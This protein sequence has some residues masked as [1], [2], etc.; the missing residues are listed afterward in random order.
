MMG[1]VV[2]WPALLAGT[3]A[4][5]AAG[6][7]A[8]STAGQAE[9]AAEDC[10]CCEQDWCGCEGCVDCHAYLKAKGNAV[11]LDAPAAYAAAGRTAWWEAL[12]WRAA[13]MPRWRPVKDEYLEARNSTL[14]DAGVGLFATVSLPAGAV[15]PP[16]KGSILTYAESKRGGPS[17]WCP[18]G[19]GAKLLGMDSDTAM[20]GPEANDLS[21][22][23]NGAAAV[24][25]NPSPL[26]NSAATK[27]ECELVNVEICEIG[28]V[29]YYRTTKPV[30][31][32]VELVTE[33][34]SNYWEDLESC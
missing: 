20:S 3:S 18:A 4:A 31:K 34:G 10:S 19:P 6:E 26:I 30:P 28:Q 7:E 16:Y 1:A 21:Y 12:D 14:E 33:Y 5:S 11:P 25:N 22:C 32:G 17:V 15:M 29:M 2:A 9:P 27:E 24:E 13:K 23:V 8:A